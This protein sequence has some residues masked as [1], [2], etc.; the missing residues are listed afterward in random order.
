[1]RTGMYG[2]IVTVEYKPKAYWR[3][4]RKGAAQTGHAWI[5]SI[6][7][8]DIEKERLL[9][10]FAAAALWYV[11]KLLWCYDAGGIAA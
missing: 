5:D 9:R 6:H 11:P 2:V 7:W 1:M 3:E 10:G 8:L 4:S